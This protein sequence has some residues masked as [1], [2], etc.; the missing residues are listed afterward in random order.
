MSPDGRSVYVANLNDY[1]AN[2][3]VSQYDIDA[4]SG[5][6]SPKTPSKVTAGRGAA[7]GIAVSPDSQSVYVANYGV[8]PA[9]GNV[10]QY[11]VDAGGALSTKSPARAPAGGGASGIAVRPLVGGPTAKE[12]C[13]DGGWREFGFKNQRRCIRFVK[14][15]ARKSCRTERDE[16]GRPAFREKHSNP[17]H[18][19][20]RAFRRCVQQATSAG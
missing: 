5:T 10:S 11:D 8:F 6:L 16:I 4:G 3:S 2:G 19:H 17:K 20:R 15:R 18:H 14:N 9:N 1:P 13:K 7:A 12:Q